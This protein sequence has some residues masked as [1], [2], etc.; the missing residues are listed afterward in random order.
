MIIRIRRTSGTCDYVKP[1]VLDRLIEDQ[2]ILSFHRDGGI[3]VLGVH[4]VRAQARHDHA[5]PER[6]IRS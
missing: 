6:R 1:H 3:A 2:A 4:P 5:G